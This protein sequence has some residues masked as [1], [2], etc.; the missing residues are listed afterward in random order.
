MSDRQRR[1]LQDHK[2]HNTRSRSRSRQRSHSGPTQPT[3]TSSTPKPASQ[4]R[5][6]KTT[7]FDSGQTEYTSSAT[8]TQSQQDSDHTESFESA[9]TPDVSQIERVTNETGSEDTTATATIS[10]ASRIDFI[11]DLNKIVG[12]THTEDS[13]N[14][15]N[16]N[17]IINAIQDL[18]T[19]LSDEEY[20]YR[21]AFEQKAS[22]SRQLT[23]KQQ[24]LEDAY[25]QIDS[26]H[27][28]LEEEQA[29]N[30]ETQ[31]V[32]IDQSIQ[33]PNQDPTLNIEQQQNSINMAN[34]SIYQYKLMPEFSG[35]KNEIAKHHIGKF[36]K[37]LDIIKLNI[38][39]N[40]DPDE[41]AWDERYQ[42]FIHT[43]QGRA[44]DWAD[45]REVPDT[46]NKKQKYDQLI[47]DF[48]QKFSQ[49]GSTYPEKQKSWTEL[50][51]E[52]DQS[53]EEFIT[54]F[55]EL[56][57]DLQKNADEK[58]DKFIRSM[59]THYGPH[60]ITCDTIDKMF[61]TLKN[62]N[63]YTP[64]AHKTSGA[65]K[66]DAYGA[67]SAEILNTLAEMNANIIKKR[68]LPG[69][70]QEIKESIIKDANFCAARAVPPKPMGYDPRPQFQRRNGGSSNIQNEILQLIRNIGLDREHCR[71]CS[72]FG[73]STLN[74]REFLN[75]LKE[76]NI[77]PKKRPSNGNGNG[78]G[79][80][81]RGN[82]FGNQRR[83]QNRYSRP[84]GQA[85]IIEALEDL[86]NEY[87]E[88]DIEQ[89]NMVDSYF[90]DP[91]NDPEDDDDSEDQSTN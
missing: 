35:K 51:W 88:D 48:R 11:Q 81:N 21:A 82:R 28:Q 27:R 67:N 8:D 72:N 16:F 57:E 68:D 9:D 26:L 61:A 87:E 63:A 69:I 56:A 65:E 84:N 90:M 44:L 41:D 25:D 50:K 3:S 46:Q 29:E 66:S 7:A 54:M 59:P 22:L 62:I 83:F 60:L 5:K 76:K 58:K 40:E 43:L 33:I 39:P 47:Q 80:G 14:A 78:N 70:K 45:N 24:A 71:Y 74:C 15:A 17:Q 34:D 32:T 49:F 55:K 10:T 6:S 79:N 91:H 77:R 1:I 4:S 20:R 12:I 18:K 37:H 38:K 23:A 13:G 42:K 30:N 53:C 86:L 85:N 2:E 64:R 19:K 36:K 75:Q 52:E 73:H 31:D 89:C